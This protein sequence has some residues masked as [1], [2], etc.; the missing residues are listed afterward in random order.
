MALKMEKGVNKVG[1]ATPGV[2]KDCSGKPGWGATPLWIGYTSASGA[3]VG[4]TIYL[5]PFY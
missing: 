5:A 3:T 1:P 2:W 4:S